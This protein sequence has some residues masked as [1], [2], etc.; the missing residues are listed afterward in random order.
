[1]KWTWWMNERHRGL[2]MLCDACNQILDIDTWYLRDPP[3][4]EYPSYAVCGD[5]KGDL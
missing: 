1:M 2:E 4:A 5:C 3:T